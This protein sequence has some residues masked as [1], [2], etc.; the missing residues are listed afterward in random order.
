MSY[1]LQI[2]PFT[3]D[4]KFRFRHNQVCPASTAIYS[5]CA[6]KHISSSIVFSRSKMYSCSLMPVFKTRKGQSKDNS[7]K[8][9]M[10]FKT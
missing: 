4:T 10:P 5:E 1:C 7:S 2:N 6:E 9:V 3:C 8:Q